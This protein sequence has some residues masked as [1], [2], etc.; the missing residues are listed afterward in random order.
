MLKRESLNLELGSMENLGHNYFVFIHLFRTYTVWD[1]YDKPIFKG[2]IEL[3]DWI[4]NGHN[5][6]RFVHTSL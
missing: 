6:N 5:S 1:I 3:R 2:G 4:W